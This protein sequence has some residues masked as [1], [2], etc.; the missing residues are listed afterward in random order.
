MMFRIRFKAWYA[1]YDDETENETETK[2]TTE[3]TTVETKEEIEKPK[4]K[5]KTPTFTPDQQAYVN[6]LVAE[7]RR[8]AKSKN[9]ALILQLETL[10]NS[11]NTTAAEKEQLADRIES[12]KAEFQTKEVN[13]RKEVDRKSKS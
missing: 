3:T 9:E 12:L 7:E 6:S 2:E 10:K 1:T 4:P 8:R 13:D 5:S 11:S